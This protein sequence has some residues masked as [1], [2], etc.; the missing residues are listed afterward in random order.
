MKRREAEEKK[1]EQKEARKQFEQERRI[2]ELNLYGPP[3][4]DHN[5]GQH[6]HQHHLAPPQP[7][8]QCLVRGD[9]ETSL[10]RNGGRNLDESQRCPLLPNKAE[11]ARLYRQLGKDLNNEQ[12]KKLQ[13]KVDKVAMY[14]F[15]CIFAVFN[16]IYWPYY[17]FL[18]TGLI[19]KT[20]K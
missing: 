5:R 15:P 9:G 20:I 1:R 10:I 17:T 4:P 6:Q 14:L 7:G 2:E 19:H 12:S 18:F 11:S 16:C 8:R 3:H 13:E